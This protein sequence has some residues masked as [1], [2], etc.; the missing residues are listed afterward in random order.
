MTHLVKKPIDMRKFNRGGNPLTKKEDRPGITLNICMSS[1]MKE[2]I[3]T[4]AHEREF[5][6][7]SEYC[8]YIFRVYHEFIEEGG[9]RE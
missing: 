9:K 8:R 6:S 3:Q 7:T 2:R 4:E 1:K 5:C